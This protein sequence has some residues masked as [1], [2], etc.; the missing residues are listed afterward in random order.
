MLSKYACMNMSAPVQTRGGVV[1]TTATPSLSV[2]ACSNRGKPTVTQLSGCGCA[3]Y[4]DAVTH[5]L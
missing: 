2:E 4:T 5:C 3:L 1:E